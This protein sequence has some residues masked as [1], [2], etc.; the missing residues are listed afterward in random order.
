[1]IKYTKLF[2]S[3]LFKK[4]SAIPGVFDVKTDDWNNSGIIHF[5]NNIWDLKALPSLDDRYTNAYDDAVQHL[6]NNDDWSIEYTFID[7]FQLLENDEDFTKFLETVVHPEFRYDIQDIEKY[8]ALINTELSSQ[9]YT[10]AITNYLNDLPVYSIRFNTNVKAIDIVENNIPFYVDKHTSTYP[11]FHLK[12]NG[13]DDYDNETTFYLTYFESKLNYNNI[14]KVKIT[15]GE[16]V[17]TENVIFK[18]FTTLPTSFCSI[19]QSEEYY[20]II[21]KVFKQKFRSILLALRDAAY[22]TEINDLFS[23]NPIFIKSLLRD[24]DVEK[25]SRNLRYILEGRSVLNKYK[26]TYNF[27]PN[28]AK[29]AINIELNYNDS[30]EFSDRIYTIIGKNGT[31]KTQ[32]ITNLPVDLSNKISEAFSPHKPLFSK[33]IA[34]SYSIFDNFN[35]PNPSTDFNYVH[36]GLLNSDKKL[37]TREEKNTELINAYKKKIKYHYR[38]DRW[39][40]ILLNFIDKDL[41]KDVFLERECEFYKDNSYELNENKFISIIDKLSSG[42]S[43]MLEIITKII[44]NIRYDSLILFDEPET[45]LHPNAIAQLISS[46]YELVEEFDSYCLITTHSP[47]IIQNVFGKNVYVMEKDGDY[48]ILRK[49]NNEC[50]GEN[51]TVLTEDVFGN[52]NVE[53]HYKVILDKMIDTYYDYEFIIS[54]LEKNKIP[55]SL[56]AKLYLKSK[57]S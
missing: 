49:I 40:N 33:V 18:G 48:P 22:F 25:L 51:L 57:L 28:Y 43:I 54:I 8:V 11:Y 30:L 12:S 31:G 27:T 19:G 53:K 55:L 10:L 44:A 52:K 32:L 37:S 21:K 15:D 26:F 14:G 16:N 7:R 38:V 29:T 39:R 24:D 9:D 23:S 5:L 6:V 20:K 13:W 17:I 3:K 2:K 41:L 36:C 47:I 4:I 34:V 56:N 50:F 1:M 45:H 42:Q 35:A 46:I